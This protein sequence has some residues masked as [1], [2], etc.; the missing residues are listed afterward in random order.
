M[1]SILT[2]LF[3]QGTDTS[4]PEGRAKAGNLAGIVGIC[5][6]ILLFL[7]KFTAGTLT[8]SMSIAADAFNNLSDAGSSVISLLGFWL[9]AQKPDEEHPFGH[10]RYEYLAGMAV[11]VMIMAIGLN[12]AKEGIVKVLHPNMPVFGWLSVCVMLVSILLK[13]WMSR[14]NRKMGEMIDSETLRATAADSRN[15]CLST[16]GVLVGAA[17]CEATGI[18]QIDGLMTIVVSGFILWNG[19]GLLTEALDPLLGKSPDPELVKMIEKTVLSYP[20]VLGMHDLLVHDYGPG[21]QFASLHIEF[22]AEMDALKAH[23]LIDNI[24]RDFWKNHHLQVVI[25]YD[26]IVTSDSEV[27]SLREYITEQVKAYDGRLSIHD[28]RVVPGDTH[29][30]VLFDLLVP[31][32]YDGDQN[33]LLDYIVQKVKEKNPAYIC[34]IKVDQSYV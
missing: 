31:P 22:A 25:H 29:T 21:N 1:T 7:G 2:R 28:L 13:L 16:A 11:C 14:F 27:S 30:N 20:T 12:L 10:A 26:P 19:Y 9:G 32:H 17:L 6:N 33:R 24:E 3:L 18:M 8:G 4:L 5:C 15:D 23:D 34:V